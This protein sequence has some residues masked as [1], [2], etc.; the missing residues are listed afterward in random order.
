MAEE[1]KRGA[2]RIVTVTV[3]DSRKRVADEAGKA[4]DDELRGAGFKVVRHV[5]L[6]DEPEFIREF[7][8]RVSNENEAEAIVLSGGT[9][10][11]PRDQTFEALESIFEKRI[12]GFGEAFRRL[13]FDQIGPHAILSRATAGVFNECVIFSL[14]GSKSGALLGVQQLIIPTLQHAV[15]LAVGRET[16]TAGGLPSSGPF[17]T[18]S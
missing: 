17:R 5:I 12:D 13:S 4:I 3:S 16:H 2:I 14:P 8:R 18:T 9:G 1:T 6:R 11:N 10:I 7:V 15:D